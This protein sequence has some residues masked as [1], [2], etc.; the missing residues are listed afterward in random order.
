MENY[1]N[2]RISQ[3][4]ILD[5]FQFKWFIIQ[6]NYTKMELIL[7]GLGKGANMAF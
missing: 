4:K 2:H 5:K 1:L 6:N 7:S 3:L